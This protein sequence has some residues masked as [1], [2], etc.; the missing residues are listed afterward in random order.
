[1][2]FLCLPLT[3]LSQNRV[4][5][6]KAN[7]SNLNI[8][9][10]KNSQQNSDEFAR[11]TTVENEEALQTK[12]PKRATNKEFENWLASKIAANK[13]SSSQRSVTAVK[14]VPIIFHII[15]DGSGADNVS[16][17]LINAQISQLNIDFGNLAGSSYSVAADTELQFCAAVVDPN[18]NDLAEPGIN[19]I[20]TYGDDQRFDTYI[21]STI[22]PNTQWDPTRYMNV[23]VLADIQNASVGSLLGYAQFP[24]TSGLSGLNAN[25]GAANTDGIAIIASSVGSTAN[26]N[27]TGGVYARGRTLTHEAGH[28]FGLRHIWG[29]GDCSA[30]DFCDDTPNASGETSGC[31]SNKDTCPSSAGNDMIENYMDYSNDTCLNTFTTDQK[32]RITA[33][34]SNSP[35]RM[36]L[37]NSDVCNASPIVKF[38]STSPGSV[39]EGSECAYQDFIVDVT[40]SS[41]STA[42][43]TA[44]V[45]TTGT[46]TI[47]KD[48]DLLNNIVTFANG[49]TT[50]SNAV[51]LRIYND[52]FIEPNEIAVT[53]TGDAVASTNTYEVS[54]TNDETV[55]GLPFG[56]GATTTDILFEDFEDVTG[57]SIID[58]DGDTFT[59]GIYN[60]T[61]FNFD[62]TTHQYSGVMALS[63]SYDLFTAATAGNVGALTPDNYLISPEMT[64]PSNA[65]DVNFS[66]IIGSIDNDTY[67]KEH[68]SIYFATDITSTATIIAGTVLENNREIPANGTELRTHNVP[69]L[70][71][72][73]GHFVIRHHNVTDE[74]GLGFD[75]LTITSS[76]TIGVQEDVNTAAP[77]NV[78][79]NDQGNLYALD[80]TSGN[81]MLLISNTAAFDYGCTE[82]TVSRS[83]TSAG[84]AA[85]Q[86]NAANVENYVTAK[87][88]DITPTNT[89]AGTANVEFYFTEDE[90]SAWET[91]TGNDRDDIYVKNATTGEI[92]A[93]TVGTFL[94][95]AKLIATITQGLAGT[96]Y[97]GIQSTLLS[98]DSFEL[99]NSISLYPNPTST[100]LTIKLGDAND[101]PDTYEIYNMLGQIINRKS[102]SNSADLTINSSALSNGMYFIRISKENTS[103]TLQFIK[104]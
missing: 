62:T 36:S 82:V 31:P 14:T 81:V 65:T 34:M 52:S 90:L 61:G 5:V 50:P 78:N 51:T 95:D 40:L 87:T 100:Q 33:V 27:P 97:F 64:I 84:S 66:Y 102:I 2:S 77:D 39:I 54:I 57:W 17:T 48:F 10:S 60:S 83:I 13:T 96:Y 86:L 41:A 45:S 56:G 4:P 35:R 93:T 29:D 30:D 20:T 22:K 25:G 101:L 12:F 53:T 63:E 23:W 26:P 69:A 85:V 32:A 1:M 8:S 68:Y 76:S 71:G 55:L 47:G 75:T 3:V 94:T 72:A 21:N 16:Q 42:A 43:V 7:V 99:E 74:L 46:A 92:V 73:T 18:G 80:P 28:F 98:V 59:W 24:S 79:I 6:T 44:T 91:A 88:F 11:C 37:A 103:T 67:Y 104:R 58:A 49:S 89:G 19:R 70:A 9:K 38:G 15:T